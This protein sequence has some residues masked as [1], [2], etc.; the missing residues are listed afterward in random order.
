V[1]VHAALVDGAVAKC[2]DGDV[3]PDSDQ[4]ISPDTD[5]I[6]PLSFS[7]KWAVFDGLAAAE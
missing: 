3:R 6:V 4:S 7:C 2:F 5:E 1:V